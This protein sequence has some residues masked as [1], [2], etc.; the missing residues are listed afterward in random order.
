MAEVRAM[1]DVGQFTA[2]IG[3]LREILAMAPDH[4]EATYRLGVALVQ[5]G[6]PSRAVW[7]L[8][9]AAE[10]TDYAIPASLLL[11]AAHFSSQ[12]FEAAVAAADHVLEQDPDRIAA[13]RLRAKG[14]IG[15]AH[16]DEAML[17]TER[18]LELAPDDYG[19]RTLH[20]TLLA[21]LDR[22]EEAEAAHDLLKEIALE[23]GDPALAHRGC[24]APAMFAREQL[25]D[26][27]KA[28]ALYDDCVERFPTS[29]F[30]TGETMRFYD[31]IGKPEKAT[32]VIRGAVEKAPENLSLRSQLATRLSNQG[33]PEAAEK[34]LL[35]AV[36]SFRSAGA[37]NLLANFYRQQGEPAKALEAIEKVVEFAGGGSDQLRFNQADVLID[38]GELE[39]A[40]QIAAS[41][42]E[43]TYAKLLRGRIALMRGD[44]RAALTLFDQ[45][46]RSWPN[47]AGARY[48]AGQAAYELGDTD[49]A[50]SELRE[51]VRVDR[52]GTAAAEVLARIHFE[53][54]DYTESLRFTKVAARR[55]GANFAE[56]YT[57]AARGFTELGQYD[58]AR[59]TLDTMSRL[60]GQEAAVAIE[61]A[62]VEREASGP[63]A[64]VRAI[65]S[66]GLSLD[67]PA[68]ERLLRAWSDHMIAKGDA[69]GALARIDA[70]LTA[71]PDSASHHEMRGSVLILLGRDEQAQA[72]F[73]RSVE[74]DA[75]YA[76]GVAG[77]ATVAARHKELGRSVELFDQAAALAPERGSYAYS[78]AQLTLAAGDTAGA[79]KRLREIVQRFPHH[80]GARNDLA[81][82]LAERG[83]ELDLA[84]E[85]ALQAQNLDPSPDVLDTL[86]WV[87]FKRGQLKEAEAALAQALEARGDSPSIRY[88]LGVV[89]SKA[90]DAERAREMLQG[91]VDAGG[92][93]EAED[94]R[95]ELAQLEQR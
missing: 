30:V 10:S 92:F 41:L 18:L 63:D 27:G 12:N 71:H 49:R 82:I 9:K 70:Y 75:E 3:E 84:L 58:D 44:P 53:R 86:G 73:A 50:V 21:D 83:E 79:E 51:A 85:L 16:L 65:E 45:G 1:Q 42:D 87:Y 56:I 81:W 62:S 43:A 95:R 23:G 5:T 15:A 19:V 25:D 72:A 61:R 20:A 80:A 8:E 2:S 4:P 57:I 11:S 76:A 77:L 64:A 35:E 32:A 52:T 13:L 7:A 89:L 46:I 22:L 48:L 26:D 28:E 33:D 31:G 14:N 37:W 93:P 69:E 24:I 40:E 47:N 54:G 74:L 66:S 6:E 78:A 38:L 94:A 34:V 39:R 36:D 29:G 88:R 67:D 60:P 68:N 91:A 90:G 17:D 59:I 55:R